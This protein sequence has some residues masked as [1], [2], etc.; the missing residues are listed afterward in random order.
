MCFVWYKGVCSEVPDLLLHALSYHVDST[1]EV[2]SRSYAARG[3]GMLLGAILA[4]VHGSYCHGHTDMLLAVAMV[5]TGG[6]TV[7][8]PWCRRSL[9]LILAGT[10]Q[11]LTQA[12]VLIGKF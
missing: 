2:V 1:H 8:V 6:C 5:I 3:V 12:V 4:G 7:A 10:G 11:G 9:Y